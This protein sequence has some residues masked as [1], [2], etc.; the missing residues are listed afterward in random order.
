MHLIHS[1]IHSG[2]F[3]SASSSLRVASDTARILCQSFTPKHHGQTVS[4]GLAL[5]PYVAA[6]AGLEPAT[7]RT[8]GVESTNVPRHPTNMPFRED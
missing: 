4:E 2:Y 8:K 5:G 1:F 3:Y 6:R 7:L